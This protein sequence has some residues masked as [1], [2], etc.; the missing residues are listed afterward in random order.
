MVSDTTDDL[1]VLR[2]W[3]EFNGFEHKMRQDYINREFGLLLEDMDDE[4]VIL[5]GGALFFIDTVF[6]IVE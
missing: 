3:L 1:K 4:N 5:K 2:E 6:Y